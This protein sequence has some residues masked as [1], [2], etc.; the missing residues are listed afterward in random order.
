MK[1][2]TFVVVFVVAF[3]LASTA[4]AWEAVYSEGGTVYKQTQG[5]DVVPLVDGA[6]PVWSPDGTEIVFL[7]K[8]SGVLEIFLMNADGSNERSLRKLSGGGS[9]T[10]SVN[11]L[12]SHYS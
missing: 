3:L 4:G 11:C 2:R 12:T 9:P 1:V 10:I 5:G 8:R 6:S 7:S